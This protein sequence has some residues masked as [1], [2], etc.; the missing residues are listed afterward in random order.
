[1]QKGEQI[2]VFLSGLKEIWDQRTSIS[3]NFHMGHARSRTD[4]ED[5]IE[6]RLIG[7]GGI[8]P[9]HTRQVKPSRL[10]GKMGSASSR[11]DQTSES[12]EEQQD[13]SEWAKRSR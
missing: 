11:S 9:E 4:G 1:M 10:G 3:A 12:E 5:H 8:C 13:G 6:R 2:D 7:L